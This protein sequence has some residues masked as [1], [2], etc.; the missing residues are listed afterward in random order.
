VVE[1]LQPFAWPGAADHDR[2][3]QPGPVERVQGLAQLQHQVVGDVHRQRHA[4]HPAAGQAHPHPQ[5]GGHGRVEA[6]CLAEHEPVARGRIV[7]AGRVDLG[8]NL[9]HVI[10]QPGVGPESA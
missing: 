10:G 8:D 7:D 4:A 1:R 2:P 3:G 6:A 9:L 5:R